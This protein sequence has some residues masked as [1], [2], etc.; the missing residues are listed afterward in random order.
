MAAIAEAMNAAKQSFKTVLSET[1]AGNTI[2]PGV[3]DIIAEYLVDE[4]MLTSVDQLD[5]GGLLS[6][7]QEAWMALKGSDMPSMHEN[8]IRRWAANEEPSPVPVLKPHVPSAAVAGM[9]AGGAV[10]GTVPGTVMADG[11]DVKNLFGPMGPTARDLAKL[12]SDKATTGLSGV[13]IVIGSVALELGRVPAAGEVVGRVFYGSD[14][15]ISEVCRQ[16]RKAGI[17]MLSSI[18][19]DSKM[20][21]I[22]LNSH[23]MY[24]VRDYTDR[25]QIEEATLVTQFWSE[26]QAV[27]PEDAV[28]R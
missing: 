27:S 22:D 6:T 20:P 9:A 21:R 3:V 26:A 28:P 19:S 14:P 10:A 11:E 4:V 18:L 12:T 23:F 15:R 5:M 13:R 24:L 7:A 2:L 17:I 25:G 16:Q 1:R 8:I